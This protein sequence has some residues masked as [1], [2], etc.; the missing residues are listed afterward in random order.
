[1]SEKEYRFA[2]PKDRKLSIQEIERLVDNAKE[3][4]IEEARRLCEKDKA[5]QEEVKKM[6]AERGSLDP[7]LS[8]IAEQ[9]HIGSHLTLDQLSELNI[10]QKEILIKGNIGDREKQ[11]LE[12][13][14]QVYNSIK[15]I[16]EY[17]PLQNLAQGTDKNPIQVI[18]E[19]HYWI[20]ENIPIHIKERFSIKQGEN[21]IELYSQQMPLRLAH[22]LKIHYKLF[23]ESHEVIA[24][25]NGNK[26]FND[27]ANAIKDF[28]ENLTYDNLETYEK[29]M[30]SN[31]RA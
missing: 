8:D 14:L 25:I 31:L 5:L 26:F 27:F 7:H 2:I 1:M 6:R 24:Q 20:N 22:A 11:I 15:E 4:P 18:Q 21:L 23:K 9:I 3:M 30:I 17:L 28:T 19:A 16:N 10:N 13:Q 12:T 29:K